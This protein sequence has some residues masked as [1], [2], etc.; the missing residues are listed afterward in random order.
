MDA[1]L[2]ELLK[3][4]GFPVFACIAMAFYVKYISE[5]YRKDF[6]S[7]HELHREESLKFVESLNN[8]TL[9]IQKL[10]DKLDKDGEKNENG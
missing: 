8:N 4:F 1:Q 2:I 3:T 6:N 10:C 5:N 9:V 7:L